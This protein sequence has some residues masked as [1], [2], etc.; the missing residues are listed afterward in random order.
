MFIIKNDFLEVND[1]GFL[2]TR[3]K[4]QFNTKYGYANNEKKIDLQFRTNKNWY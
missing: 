4:K 2:R 3:C 1:V